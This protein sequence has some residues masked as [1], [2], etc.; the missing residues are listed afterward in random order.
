MDKDAESTT[1]HSHGE[2]RVGEMWIR[3]I[4]VGGR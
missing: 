3:M 4:R 2:G 1:A